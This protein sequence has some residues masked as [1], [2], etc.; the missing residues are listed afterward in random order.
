MNPLRRALWAEALKLRG[1]L[2]LWMCA[3]A[4]AV[5]VALL[6]LQIT[7]SDFTQRTPM[8]S[9]EAWTR[10]AQSVLVLWA[11]LMLPLFVTLQSA[12]LAGLEHA[13]QQWKHLLA[14]PLPRS[15]HYLAKQ[16][17][18]TGMLALAMALLAI[19][20]ALGGIILGV[21]QPAFGIAGAPPWNYLIDGVSACFAASLLIVS[22]HNWISIRWRSFTVVVSIGMG[23]TVAGYL[24][25][26]SE[27]FGHLY[28]WSMPAQ[29]FA[30]KG[31]WIGFV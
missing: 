21:L 15:A 11:F 22:L 5:V 19:F 12:L 10:F 8:E 14:L 17:A 26:Q 20:I 24:I 4:P 31:E 18:L 3:I 9:A 30:G 2:A 13:N 29:V 25:G 27:R 28:P 7:F 23:A 1:T 6:V 16:V